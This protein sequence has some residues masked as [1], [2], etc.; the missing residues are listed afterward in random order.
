MICLRPLSELSGQTR[1]Q[2][3]QE[4]VKT[5]QMLGKWQTAE[6]LF[7]AGGKKTSIMESAEELMV[8]LG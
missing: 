6:Q 2:R 5:L 1:L 8:F 7:A 4:N 3:E